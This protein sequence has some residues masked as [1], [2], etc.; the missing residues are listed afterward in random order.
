MQIF[1][2]AELNAMKS[3]RSCGSILK[4]PFLS[5]G[6]F[7]LANSYL[8]ENEL[9]K[10]E[11]RYPLKVYVCESCFLVQLEEL[12]AAEDIFSSHYAYFSS[13]SESWLKHCEGYAKTMVERFGFNRSSFV[14]EIASNDG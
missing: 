9:N 10:I 1:V 11:P 2:G 6:D 14:I 4:R 5:L 7:P 3:C 13:Y 8:V 12:K